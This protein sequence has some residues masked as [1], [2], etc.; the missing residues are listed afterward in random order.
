MS[1]PVILRA[2]T[3]RDRSHLVE[4]IPQNVRDDSDDAGSGAP[5]AHHT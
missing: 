3:L 4:I 5:F 2:A 1:V